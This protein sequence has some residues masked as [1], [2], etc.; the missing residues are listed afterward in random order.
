MEQNTQID[1]IT[2]FIQ[3]T[4]QT[5]NTI[6]KSI[7]LVNKVVGPFGFQKISDSEYSP[8]DIAQAFRSKV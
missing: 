1:I 2:D 5:V 6:G 7:A 3:S 4:I 8:V